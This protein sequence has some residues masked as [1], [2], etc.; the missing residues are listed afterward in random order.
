MS[1]Y[2]ASR[3]DDRQTLSGLDAVCA[4]LARQVMDDIDGLRAAVDPQ[5]AADTPYASLHPEDASEVA[6]ATHRVAETLTACMIEGR[7]LR[8]SEARGM[9]LLGRRRAETG[10][11]L[12]SVVGAII[13][14]AQA[15]H[16]LLER[17]ATKWPEPTVAVAALGRLSRRL[18]GAVHEA[19]AWVTAGYRD[20]EQ[21][22]TAH[23][24]RGQISFVED[25][26]GGAWS[27]TED[28]I[29]R[30]RS[31][32][33]ALTRRCVLVVLLP[34]AERESSRLREATARFV[35]RVGP[36]AITGP[37]RHRGTIHGAVLVILPDETKDTAALVRRLDIA[38][39]EARVLAIAEPVSDV[40]DLAER[41]EAMREEAGLARGVS[42]CPR[43]LLRDELLEARVLKDAAPGEVCGYVNAVLG[44][45]LALPAKQAEP[46]LETLDAIFLSPD[47]PLEAVADAIHLSHSG[48]RYRVGKI[49]RLTGITWTDRAARFRLELALRLF[50]LHE[51]RLP[52]L[53]DP[54]WRRCVAGGS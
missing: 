18:F 7:G 16:E 29:E 35:R 45:V 6:R 47:A 37:M 39:T 9:E 26:L 38:A 32:G 1:E 21:D 33:Y 46:L 5:V 4:E 8:A 15:G 10:I 19:T 34:P 53:G 52:A 44:P 40:A 23:I 12:V 49:A 24:L 3:R 48:I 14:G 27:S 42:R 2:P 36:N 31:L 30:G 41:Y 22:R 28:I 17:H 13:N 11:P 51:P 43:V 50:R 54:T 20:E 25:V